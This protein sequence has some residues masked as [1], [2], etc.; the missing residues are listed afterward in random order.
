[1]DI[2]NLSKDQLDNKRVIIK[3]KVWIDDSY[4][5]KK[6]SSFESQ[7]DDYDILYIL[8][9]NKLDNLVLP[10]YRLHINDR[11]FGYVTDYL[12]KYKTIRKNIAN[13]NFSYK[14]KLMVIK[15]LVN[16]VKKM[17]NESEIAHGDLHASN[18]IIYKNDIKIIDF[19]NAGI[20]GAIPEKYY[21][22]RKTD[23]MYCLSIVLLNILS[24]SAIVEEHYLFELIDIMT[25][26]NEFKDYLKNCIERDKSVLDIYPDEYIKEINGTI[27]YTLKNR[28]KEFK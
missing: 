11:P 22:K 4:V 3:D 9:E 19:D 7:A 25:V 14:Q 28:A 17:H 2:I 21:N 26:S 18:T 27:E 24:N 20:K 1:M 5:F 13:N 23:D 6:S 12:S 16:V 10:K 8:K 15:K